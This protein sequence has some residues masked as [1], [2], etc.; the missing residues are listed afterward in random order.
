[1]SQNVETQYDGFLDQITSKLGKIDLKLATDVMYYERK[2]TDVEPKV[3][4]DVHYRNGTNMDKKK[5]ELEASYMVARE[6]ENGIRAVGLASLA[7]ILK[8]AKILTLK[9]LMD[10]LPVRLTRRTSKIFFSNHV[11]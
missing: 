5:Y 2:F 1:M 6:G 9:R 8:L 7:D 11:R 3:E 4:L 10:L